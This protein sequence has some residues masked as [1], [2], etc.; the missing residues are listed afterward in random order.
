MTSAPVFR[1]LLADDAS[2]VRALTRRALERTGRFEVVGEAGDGSQAVA[3]AGTLLP[4]LVLL[5]LSMP[6]MDGM[7]AL[8]LIRE[9]APKALIVVLSGLE[10]ER[11]APQVRAKGASAFMPKALTPGRI[12]E[13][14]LA[15]MDE[16]LA[17]VG[18]STL[19]EQA[20]IRLQA[21]PL[22]ARRARRFV[23]QT[24]LA[25]NCSHLSDIVALLTSELV[26]NAVLHA[27]SPA[28]LTLRTDGTVL[29]ISV[30]DSSTQH[31]VVRQG[32]E[33]STHGRGLV[34]L[35]AMATSWSVVGTDAGKVVWFEV[36]TQPV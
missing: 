8:P 34:L 29:R 25:W 17:E 31:P 12:A 16:G 20:S 32:L 11:M 2:D 27:G 4:D 22:S 10:A 13:Q 35:D 30:A 7:T 1:V 15:F 36:P 33:D 5:D 9:A 14:L 3:A 26:T 18:D 28:Q 23:E 21:E 24:L 19:L 6:V